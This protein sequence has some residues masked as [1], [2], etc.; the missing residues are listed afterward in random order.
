MI[1]IIPFIALTS[2]VALVF[3]VAIAAQLSFHRREM[4]A[5][6]ARNDLDSAL[7]VA[8]M[9]EIQAE[10]EVIQAA[11]RKARPE[12]VA[13]IDDIEAGKTDGYLQARIRAIRS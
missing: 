10:N 9:G 5:T 2:A 3:C 13:L 11:K 8:V 1:W 4:R 7:L 6:F 12:S